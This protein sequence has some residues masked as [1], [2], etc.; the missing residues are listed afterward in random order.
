MTIKPEIIIKHYRQLWHVE[1]AFRLAK[2]DLQ[3]RPIYH[4]KQEAIQAHILI[5]FMALSISKYLE[6]KT[7]KSVKKIVQLL[8]T[9]T[10]A[11][12]LN[13]LTNQ[14]FILR[15]DIP[16]ELKNILAKLGLSY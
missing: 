15:S 3:I 12:I 16:S 1:Q 8:K 14:E 2:S 9:V 6:I 7:G 4:F 11:R 10:D 5:C 13:T